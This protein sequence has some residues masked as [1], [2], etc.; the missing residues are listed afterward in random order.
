[1]DRSSRQASH[2]YPSTWEGWRFSPPAQSVVAFQG[3]LK[4]TGEE[5]TATTV[6]KHFYTEHIKRSNKKLLNL[7]QRKDVWSE[8]RKVFFKKLKYFFP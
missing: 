1:M 8:R 5:K 7:L 3:P 2:C 6:Q 4:G